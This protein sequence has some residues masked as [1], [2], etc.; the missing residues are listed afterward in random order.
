LVLEPGVYPAAVT[1]FDDR[2]RVDMA[3]VARLLAWFET[4]GCAG[5][6]LAGTN[7]EGPSLSAVEKRDLIENAMHLRGALKLVLGVATPSLH[8][9]Q[10]LCRRAGDA[11][12]EAALVMPPFYYRDAPEE[13]IE[14]WFMALLDGA[15][16]PLIL[17][18]FP[19]KAGFALSSTLVEKLCRH[20]R[21]AGV[22]D[23]SGEPENL[24]PY[25]EAVQRDDQGLFVGYEP[26]LM[27]ALRAGW[28]GSI[29]GAANVAPL[30]LSAVVE[31][32]HLGKCESAEA[33][34]S[35]LQPVLEESRKLK[36]PAH[37]KGVLERFGVI[38]NGCVRPPLAEADPAAAD[39]LAEMIRRVCGP[40]E[41][42][43]PAAS[44]SA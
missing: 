39:C 43:R 15:P 20:P 23:S 27:D 18:N 16:L 35:L 12:A 36:Q 42:I 5:A 7:G 19:Q 24:S 37:Y 11:G 26:L 34:F 44:R 13:G 21:C 1:P 17:Y 9:A 22:K 28:S 31:D 32:F 4:C 38:P 6:V 30:P 3:A 10:W 2:G 14:R 33:K 8:E 40:P 41:S 29:S 25:R